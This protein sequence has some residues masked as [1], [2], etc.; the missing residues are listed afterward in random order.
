MHKT[1]VNILV[2]N[3]A[4]GTELF[5][6]IWS[7]FFYHNDILINLKVKTNFLNK[8]SSQI[9][10]CNVLILSSRYFKQSKNTI[11]KEGIN[12]LKEAKEK[13]VKIVWFDLRDSAGTTQFEVL[14]Y[15]DL[16][17]KKQL[18]NDIELYK[19]R[20][21]GG[22]IY[23]D[24][25]HKNFKVRDD[26]N[27]KLITLNDVYKKK[28]LLAWNI[29]VRFFDLKPKNK[30]LEFLNFH[31]R[32]S[33]RKRKL[34]VI[35]HNKN[36]KNNLICTFAKNIER[37]TVRFQ[38][39]YFEQYLKK[40]FK[41][42]NSILFQKLPL[43]KYYKELKLSKI[44]L[45]LFGWGEICYREFESVING[46]PFMMPNMSHIKTYPNIYKNNETYIPI[47]WDFSDFY[48]KYLLLLNN[49]KLRKKLVINAQNEIK[50]VRK[51]KGSNYFKTIFEKIIE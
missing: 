24:Y 9:F 42:E 38:R 2:S 7:P 4:A 40:N 20:F 22:R 35:K 5:K 21:Y 26:D 37:N 13:K 27:Y 43:K 19:N 28:I 39:E 47:N 30:Y 15:V 17:L 11:D 18:Y 6:G 1:V 34:L 8:V 31:F 36:R 44:T 23:C 33:F 46:C 41:L 51:T 14:P 32:S 50:N 12:F 49:Y 25:Y 48:E 3:E 16:Y 45:S 10:K 29:G